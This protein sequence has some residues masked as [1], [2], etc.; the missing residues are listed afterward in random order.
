M[1]LL[2]LIKQ[3]VRQTTM[4]DKVHK[5]LFLWTIMLKTNDFSRPSVVI[6]FG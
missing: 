3:L 4:S 6:V 5:M 2:F 1:V